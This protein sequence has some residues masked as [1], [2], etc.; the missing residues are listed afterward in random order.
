MDKNQ[1]E[2]E[3]LCNWHEKVKSDGGSYNFPGID[4]D[5]ESYFVRR[6]ESEYLK[7][8]NFETLP[9]IK[10]ELDKMWE[11]QDYMQEIIKPV[12]TAAMKNK[13]TEEQKINDGDVN[14]KCGE[15]P[16]FIYNF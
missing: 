2:K 10:S 3:F 12:L 6:E 5:A 1:K 7:E 8:Y 4:T 16:V 9:Q 11:G 14:S 15:I 13:P